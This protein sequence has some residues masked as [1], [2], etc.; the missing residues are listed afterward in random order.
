MKHKIGDKIIALES[1]DSTCAHPRIKGNIYTVSEILT[2]SECGTQYI[3]A[4][5]KTTLF[6]GECTNCNSIQETRGFKWT[7]SIHFVNINDS[8]QIKFALKEAVEVEDYNF[9]IILRDINK[10]LT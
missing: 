3:S 9:A 2:C 4:G 7:P 10:V 8:E 1:S 5:Y 6:D